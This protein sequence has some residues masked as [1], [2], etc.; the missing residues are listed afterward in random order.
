MSDVRL[1]SKEA[2]L[3][4]GGGGGLRYLFFCKNMR[5]RRCDKD[6]EGRGREE[7]DNELIIC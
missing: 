1:L 4:V 6:K 7:V 3:A 5:D 2:M